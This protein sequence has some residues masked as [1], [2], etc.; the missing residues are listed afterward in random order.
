MPRHAYACERVA[1]QAPVRPPTVNGFGCSIYW[2]TPAVQVCPA[3]HTPSQAPQCWGSLTALMQTPLHWTSPEFGHVGQFAALQGQ[4]SSSQSSG[5]SSQS[6]FWTPLHSGGS[7]PAPQLSV[8]PH[9]S[10]TVAHWPGWHV[11]GVQ[12]HWLVV[13]PPPHVWGAPHTPQF[14]VPP[15][16]SGTEPQLAPAAAHVVGTQHTFGT[17]PAPQAWPAGHEPQSSVP[18]HPSGTVPQLTPRSPHVA[19]TQAHWFGT[20]PAPQ[21]N[22]SGH[23]PQ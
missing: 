17:P 23:R 12:P 21:W 16:P 19:G 18:P 4:Q 5:K 7:E 2:Q 14:N 10:G 1:P 9:P 13:P 20:P 3:R 8:P 22:P 11:E 15:H 6:A